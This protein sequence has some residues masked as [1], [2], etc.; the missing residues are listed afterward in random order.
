MNSC[1][2]Y[3]RDYTPPQK[4]TVFLVSFLAA[5]CLHSSTDHTLLAS[6]QLLCLVV[7]ARKHLSHDSNI[8]Q[9][10]SFSCLFQCFWGEIS[11]VQLRQT[12]SDEETSWRILLCWYLEHVI[13]TLFQTLPGP[14]SATWILRRRSMRLISS[15]TSLKF[16]HK[17][18]TEWQT[19][20]APKMVTHLKTTIFNLTIK[21]TI[22]HEKY[23]SKLNSLPTHHHSDLRLWWLIWKIISCLHLQFT[24][25]KLDNIPD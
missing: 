24:C 12:P 1:R 8:F 7:A 9:S 13:S 6:Q 16:K 15:E 23:C 17:L 3:N 22:Y 19:H 4:V 21:I 14:P 2:E 20:R 5:L 11:A 10:V 18:T 25:V